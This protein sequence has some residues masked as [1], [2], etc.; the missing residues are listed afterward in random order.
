MLHLQALP[1]SAGSPRGDR[2]LD[3][4][5]ARLI[6]EAR[7]LQEVGFHAAIIENFG[8]VPFFKDR[9]D[10]TTIAVMTRLAC[11]VRAAV[12]ELPLGINV[13]RNDAR[14]ALAV[15]VAAGAKFIRV[16]VHVGATA[17]DQ[18]VIEGRAA[19]TLRARA[20]LGADIAIWSDVH[21]KHGR[22]LAHAS[23]ADEAEDAVRRGRADALVVSGRG[24]GEATSLD[25]LRAVAEL[26]LG[27]P[28]YVGSGVNRRE[29]RVTPRRRR[30]R[31][32][33]NVDQIRQQD[34]QPDRQK[35][36]GA[37]GRKGSAEASL[38]HGDRGAAHMLTWVPNRIV[39]CVA[40]NG[41][42]R[43]AHPD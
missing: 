34:D 11:A 18:G 14:A 5:E 29:R 42:W 32:R 26:D 27:V 43:R 17:T 37:V 10:A 13:L 20:A 6:A 8:D 41:V 21:V 3:D 35:A 30:R 4:I 2:S 36:G 33:R 39:P 12:H 1:G 24:T 7:L 23:I 22:S 16:N 28:I 38:V 15:A 40:D 31:H 9:V 25:D 19:E